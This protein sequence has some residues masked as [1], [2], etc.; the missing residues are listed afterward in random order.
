MLKLWDALLSS[1]KLTQTHF[2][3]PTQ[4]YDLNHTNLT[5]RGWGEPQRLG[6][7]KGRLGNSTK[8]PVIAPLTRGGRGV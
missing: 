8:T 1:Q 5:K 6:L 4:G 3:N 2:L 7:L